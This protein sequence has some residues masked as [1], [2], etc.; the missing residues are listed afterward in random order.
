M[1]T[2]TIVMVISGAILL[3][4]FIGVS[5]LLGIARRKTVRPGEVEYDEA[6]SSRSSFAENLRVDLAEAGIENVSVKQFMTYSIVLGVVTFLFFTFLFGMWLLG[7]IGGFAISVFGLRYMYVGR[8]ASARH[9]RI[10]AQVAAACRATAS[11]MRSGTEPQRAFEMFARRADPRSL[12]RELTG[13][14]DEVAA[15]LAR[16]F[17]M[18]EMQAISRAGALTRSANE[19]GNKYLIQMV[20]VFNQNSPIS[21]EQ[22][23]DA[24]LKYAIEVDYDLKLQDE[25]RTAVTQQLSSY[26]ILGVIAFGVSMLIGAMVGTD[27]NFFTTII[28]QIVLM[29]GAAWWLTGF[30]LQ[31]RKINER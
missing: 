13:E 4:T 28:G 10:S 12:G 25:R 15:T 1:D 16:A 26:A 27:E 18:A 17:R 23:A 9:G 7:A 31:R 11:M 21:R 30:W 22:T 20:E 19:L 24:L 29:F 6:L 5:E 3:G 8:L 2:S 14:R